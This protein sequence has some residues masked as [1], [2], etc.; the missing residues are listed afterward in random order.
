MIR[1]VVFVLAFA[2]A[3][4]GPSFA[5]QAACTLFKVNT[6]MLNI[7]EQPAG[8]RYIDALYDGDVACVTRTTSANAASWGF[9]AQ[10]F[11]SPTEAT[12]VQGWAPLTQLQQ[13]SPAEAGAL[14]EKA[15]RQ[16]ASH[17]TPGAGVEPQT[18]PAGPKPAA[19]A[20][21]APAAQAQQAAPPPP[22]VPSPAA[23]EPARGNAAAP[24]RPEEVLHFDQPIPFGPF[25]VNGHS[26]KEMIDTVPLFSPIE[27]LDDE[28]AWKKNCTS[29]HQWNKER[30]CQ[31]ALTYVR[32]P[33]FVLRVPHP[34]GGALKLA[35]MR[36][37]KSGCD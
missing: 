10:K 1:R 15:E 18:S 12:P 3:G 21:A 6:G 31:Q 19:P 5:Q 8:E 4:A 33:R 25:P 20:Q 14:L 9:I 26:I 11:E 7:A 36:W 28:S 29:C 30:L 13:I 16:T 27:G 17:T 37:A 2:C 24:M 35:L 22:A 34:F 23:G 32:Q